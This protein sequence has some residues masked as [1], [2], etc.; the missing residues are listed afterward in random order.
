MKTE[1]VLT[2]R[3]A[4]LAMRQYLLT[5]FDLAG[6]DKVVHLGGLLAEMEPE[7]DGTTSD[8]GAWETFLESIEQ[9][10]SPDYSS[11]WDEVMAHNP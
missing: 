8:N 6:D 7:R 4:Y 5:E 3:Q 1:P 9:V 10:L 11:N 2:S